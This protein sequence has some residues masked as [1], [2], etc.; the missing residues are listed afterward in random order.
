[1]KSPSIAQNPPTVPVPIVLVGC[2][3]V[4]KFFYASAIQALAPLGWVRLRALVDPVEANRSVLAGIFPDV[5]QHE[6]VEEVPLTTED[7]VI[8]ATPPRF[9]APVAIHALRSGASVLVEKPIACSVQEGKLMLEAEQCSRGF[10]AVGH[11]RRFYASTQALREV[12]DNGVLGPLKRFEITECAAGWQAASD[13]F[14]RPEV[15]GG[16][17]FLDVGIHILDQ[18]DAWLGEPSEVRYA[19]DAM[20]GLEA[21]AVCHLRYDSGVV[22]NVRLSKER[23]LENAH[24]FEFEKGVVRWQVGKP[25]TLEVQ[26]EGGTMSV[27]GSLKRLDGLPCAT[28]PQSFIEQ[29]RHVA[30]VKS[31]REACLRIPASQAIRALQVVEQAYASRRLIP[32]PWLSEPEQQRVMQG[33]AEPSTPRS[34]AQRVAI[35][36]ASGFLGSRLVESMLLGDWEGR[37]VPWVRSPNSL[38]RLARFSLESKIADLFNLEST[39]TALKGCEALV[40]CALGDEGQIV[41]MARIIGEAC[42]Q[43]N[44]RRVVV[45]STAAV[46]GLVAPSGATDLMEPDPPRGEGYSVAKLQAERV[47]QEAASKHGFELVIVRPSLIYGPRSQR[48][49]RLYR[50]LVSGVAGLVDKGAGVFNGIYVDN[51]VEAIRL[52]LKR[53]EAAG[54]IFYV[55]DAEPTTWSDV[56]KAMGADPVKLPAIEPPSIP[57]PGFGQRVR[58]AAAQPFAQKLLPYFPWK[59]KS[60]TKRILAALPEPPQASAWV[61]AHTGRNVEVDFELAWLQTTQWRLPQDRATALLGYTPPVTFEEGMRRTCLW[62]EFPKP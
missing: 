62:M 36:G 24:V 10:L 17:I 40:H 12:I 53:P 16:G 35:T 19:D 31:G 54:Q 51:L 32:M 58:N 48:M 38:A 29:L 34:T 30:A 6:R 20:G 39:V 43:A 25:D 9:H 42:H 55:G 47:L 23:V 26:L 45:I 22:G 3:A 28:D 11:V 33:A 49:E 1:M 2:G 41:Q 52:A 7:L 15:A 60:V 4:S 8:V 5:I 61:P 13:S 27:S 57:T 50:Q 21:N 46:F 59:L 56:Y 44:V 18:L 14:F 37:P